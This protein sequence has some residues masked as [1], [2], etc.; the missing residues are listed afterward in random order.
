MFLFDTKLQKKSRRSKPRSGISAEAKAAAKAKKIQQN[1]MDSLQITF[2]EIEAWIEKTTPTLNRMTRELDKASKYFENNNKRT[3]TDTVRIPSS[4][5]NRATTITH[6]DSSPPSPFSLPNTSP[7]SSSLSAF[8]M[9][10][11]LPTASSMQWALSFQPGNSMRLETNIKSVEQ[12]IDAV[13]KIRLMTESSATPDLCS[14]DES[15][16]ALS[17]SSVVD[18]SIEY[19]QHA[20][21]RRPHTCL[22]KYKHCDMNLSHLTEDISPSVLRYICQTYWDCLHPKFTADWSTFWSRSNDSGRNQI[23]IDSGLA[24]IFLHIIRHNRNACANAHGIAYYYYDRAREVLCFD[25]P[26]VTT[27]ETLLNLSLFCVLCKRHSQSRIYLSLAYRMLHQ[28]GLGSKSQLPVEDVAERKALLNIHMVLYYNDVTVSVYSGEPSL[29]DDSIHDIDFYEMLEYAT[30]QETF[31]VHI[32]ELTRIGKRI[33]L[34]VHDYQRQSLQHHHTGTLP[35]KWIKLIRSLEVSLAH[36]FDLLPSFYRT[37]NTQASLLL[38][39]QYQTEWIKLHKAFVSPNHQQTVSD[40]EGTS[41]LATTPYRTDRSYNICMDAANRI[42]KMAETINQK[43]D[44]CVCQQ[45][46]SCVYQA[47]TVFCKSISNK[48]RHSAISKLMIKRIMK[49]L[50]ASKMNYQGLPD[51]LAACLTEFLANN[52]ASAAADVELAS[53]INQCDIKLN[54]TMFNSP[55]MFEQCLKQQVAC[56]PL[57]LNRG[58][59]SEAMLSIK[60]QNPNVTSLDIE[61]SNKNWR[62]KFSSSNIAQVDHRIT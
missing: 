45:F 32:V 15:E 25:E 51:D 30:D 19:W 7:S 55:N 58:P 22:E 59:P 52:D 60:I 12:L 47:S 34:L 41:P 50:A 10:Q 23:C 39:M 38:M 61:P 9:K 28:L 24:M 5:T 49:V 8:P 17:A 54:D 56:K 33:Q 43:Y 13:E 4:T 62:C 29:I 3:K 36:W 20:M 11:N 46:I 53:Y 21:Y 16:D 18:P 27:I 1:N 26:D 35:F 48:D 44:W 37:Q 6:T 57:T 2:Y 40:L 14:D 31:F 42:I